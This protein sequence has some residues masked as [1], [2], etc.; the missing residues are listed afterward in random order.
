[1]RVS[2]PVTSTVTKRGVTFFFRRWR[3]PSP[4]ARIFI[5]HGLGGHSGYYDRVSGI[6]ATAGFEVI[7][8]DRRG[9]GQ[10][11]GR[12]GDV[13][14]ITDDVAD[15][16]ELIADSIVSDFS[17]PLALLSDSWGALLLAEF[18]AHH[19]LPNAAL[20]FCSP[21]VGV[22]IRPSWVPFLLSST[23]TLLRNLFHGDFLLHTGPPFPLAL[24][25]RDPA[26]V[27]MAL[28]DPYTARQMT[29]RTGITTLRLM[30]RSKHNAGLLAA[31]VLVISCAGD[32][33]VGRRAVRRFVS[34]FHATT[35]DWHEIPDAAHTW[36]WDP[37]TPFVCSL[38]DD[39]LRQNLRR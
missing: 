32:V 31:P 30:H 6:L 17:L 1:M 22:C 12:R 29:L 3:P 26:F 24:S 38:I 36:H 34:S 23:A 35:P 28:I 14:N 27:Q 8:Y 18:A 39:W 2:T 37:K 20:L 15:L 4:R 21:G 5:L 19:P 13:P 16:G 11:S 9:H 7:S 10:S 25:S 33:I